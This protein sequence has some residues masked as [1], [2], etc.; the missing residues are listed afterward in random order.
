MGRQV[1]TEWN[2]RATAYIEREVRRIGLRPAGTDGYFQ[3]VPVGQR[4]LDS[5]SV[6]RIGGRSLRIGTDFIAQIPSGG[7]RRVS[8][9]EAI[10]GGMAFDTLT[11][12]TD[13]SWRGK[14]VVFRTFVPPSGFNPTAFIA[15]AGYRRFQ[16][17]Q[18]EAAA[19]IF[20]MPAALAPSAARAALQGGN[21][22]LLRQGGDS[23]LTVMV[24]AD[25]GTALMGQ[26]V[27]GL[28]PGARGGRV[29]LDIRMRDI[30]R[31]GSRNVVAV[32]PG[33]DPTLANEYVAIGAHN[34]HVGFTRTPVDH[35]SLW[36][37]NKVVR[38]QGADSPNRPASP[39]EAARIRSVIDSLRRIR[40]PRRDSIRNG[41]DDDGSGSMG[42]LEIA[43]AFAALPTKP[44]RSVLFVWHTGEE[45][46]LWGADHF[47]EHPTV[48]REAIV[49]QLNIDMIGR[50]APEDITGSAKGG[51]LLHGDDR[52]LQVIGS[53]RLSS[54][55][56]DIVDEVNGTRPVSFR[57]DY[58]MDAN[59][60]PQNIYC[61]S[62]H[63]MYA[64]FGI[65]VAFFTTGG[66][67]DYHQVTDEP[68]YLRYGHMAEVARFIGEVARR[69]ADADERPVVDKP[70]PDRNAGCQQ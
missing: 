8:A 52:Y 10:Y 20:V 16:E 46:G 48:P 69:V 31:P 9:S 3:E 36:A 54:E 7:R 70:V 19:V 35:D 39:A 47:T 68:Q 30:V 65:P 21:I 53:R 33:S 2:T 32:L 42:L 4:V 63:Y 41:A 13:G 64:R 62:D 61:R 49:A 38:P 27:S 60:H 25:V 56:G 6:V 40:P 57:L 66:H 43:E 18:R 45:A 12:P 26:P 37:F 44:R 15:S 55:L 34:D 24:P 67:A 23:L 51:G 14:V 58:A 29:E 11:V 1:G 59:G 22:T 50:G 17:T 5:A 28:S